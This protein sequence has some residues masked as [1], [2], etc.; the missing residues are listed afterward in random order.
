MWPRL[1]Y[2]LDVFARLFWSCWAAAVIGDEPLGLVS[3][4]L[5]HVASSLRACGN[6]ENQKREDEKMAPKIMTSSEI[7]PWTL[8]SAELMQYMGPQYL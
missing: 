3:Y 8:E 1:K 7:P 4:S 2:V 5:A 6:A